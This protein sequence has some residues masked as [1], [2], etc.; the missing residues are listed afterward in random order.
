MS[1]V[2]KSDITPDFKLFGKT[3][4]VDD[5]LKIVQSGLGTATHVTLSNLW[6]SKSS[7]T[8]LFTSNM[9]L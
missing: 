5:L 6:L 2:L 4:S 8:A 1:H 9:S 7:S 3:R